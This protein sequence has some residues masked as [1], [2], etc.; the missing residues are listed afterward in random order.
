VRFLFVGVA[1]SFQR[2]HKC[3]VC[4]KK[5][6][7]PGTFTIEANDL[8]IMHLE[9]DSVRLKESFQYYHVECS[10]KKF[11]YINR[12]QLTEGQKKKL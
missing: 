11:E 8:C 7:I 2:K 4:K 6:N 1:L 5:S 10:G 9:T 12:D 3:A